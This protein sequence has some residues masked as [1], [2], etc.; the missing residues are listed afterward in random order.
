M[1]EKT[2][3][4]DVVMAGLDS[5]PQDARG[6]LV[7]RAGEDN[8]GG[9]GGGAGG[10]GRRGGGGR[11]VDEFSAAALARQYVASLQPLLGKVDPAAVDRVVARLRR[12]RETGGT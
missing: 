1:V 10:G 4:G 9:G 7:A 2:R 8:G 12:A 3:R 5:L 6:R 11:P